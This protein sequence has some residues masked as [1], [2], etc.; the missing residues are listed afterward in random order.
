MRR[1]DGAEKHELPSRDVRSPKFRPAEDW[2]AISGTPV[3]DPERSAEDQVAARSPRRLTAVCF[4]SLISLFR[5]AIAA[6]HTRL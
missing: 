6:G 5:Y 4:G 3:H 1:A 2:S